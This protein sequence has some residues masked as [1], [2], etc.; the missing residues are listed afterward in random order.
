[1]DKD[2]KAEA[3]LLQMANGPAWLITGHRQK[4]KERR[5]GWW[6]GADQGGTTMLR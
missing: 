4:I 5:P 3:A 2:A 6:L 1:M